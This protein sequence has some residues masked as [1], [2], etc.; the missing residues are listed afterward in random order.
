L[1]GLDGDEELVEAR[2]T[3][4]GGAAQGGEGKRKIGVRSWQPSFEPLWEDSDTFTE[5]RV[6]ECAEMGRRVGE[7][8]GAVGRK[9]GLRDGEGRVGFKVSGMLLSLCVCFGSVWEDMG[10]GGTV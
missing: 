8:A 4:D 2:Q 7:L 10:R 9:W 1:A 3:A 6:R 5:E